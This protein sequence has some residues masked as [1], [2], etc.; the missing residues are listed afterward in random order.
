M[1]ALTASV[2]TETREFYF[3]LDGVFALQQRVVVRAPNQIV[4]AFVVAPD[5]IHCLAAFEKCLNLQ[6]ALNPLRL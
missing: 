1:K 4:D 3:R 5:K 6:Q 2:T